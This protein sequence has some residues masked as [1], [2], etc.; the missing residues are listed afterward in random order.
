MSGLIAVVLSS[1]G[2]SSG[3]RGA[4]SVADVQSCLQSAGYGVTAIPKAE[5][6]DGGSENRGAGQT[7]E[8]LVGRGGA[9]PQVGSDSADAV[10]AFWKSSATAKRSP[11]AQDNRLGFHADAFGSVT[12]QPTTH[13][14][15]FAINSAKTSDARRAAFEAQVKKIE[16]C[17][18]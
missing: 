16:A 12:V 1:C 8:L 11:N 14:L 3:S 9:P 17:A 4:R 10:V 7:G 15:L 6:A 13:L 2:G 5:I 18:H